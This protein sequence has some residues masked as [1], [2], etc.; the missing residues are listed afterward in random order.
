MTNNYYSRNKVFEKVPCCQ[1]NCKQEA[2]MSLLDDTFS[3][4]SSLP[5]QQT[6]DPI[7]EE[8]MEPMEL[9]S[10]QHGSRTYLVT[11]SRANLQKFST[12]KEFGQMVAENFNSG[13]SK[14]RVS[15]WACCLEYHQDGGKH[16]HASLKLDRVKKWSQVK[17][18]ISSKH[19]IQLNFRD[20]PFY[21]QAYR[22]VCKKEAP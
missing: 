15:H 20:V 19:G 5:I 10:Y 7:H 18:N 12:P 1:S 11:Y 14:T 16:Y 4:S 22:Y 6:Q 2:T 8:D 3:S 13:S 21:I 9:V 17:K